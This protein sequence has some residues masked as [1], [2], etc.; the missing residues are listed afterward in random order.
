MNDLVVTVLLITAL[1][2]I[3]A[4]GVWIGLALAGVA[5]IGMQ[6]FASRPAGDVSASSIFSVSSFQP[7]SIACWMRVSSNACAGRNAAAGVFTAT[8]AHSSSSASAIVAGDGGRSA[9]S[10]AAS[11]RRCWA[12]SRHPASYPNRCR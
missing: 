11:S 2:A 4:S 3:L 6:L 9:C 7:A 1:F 8:A 12:S 10:R 5:W